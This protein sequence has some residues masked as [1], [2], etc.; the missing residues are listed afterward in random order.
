MAKYSLKE[1]GSVLPNTLEIF[2]KDIEFD[3]VS[4]DIN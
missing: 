4:T 3:I 2:L 1:I